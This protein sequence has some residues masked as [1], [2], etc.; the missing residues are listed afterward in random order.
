[1]REQQKRFS[2]QQANVQKQREPPAAP[3]VDG[4]WGRGRDAADN[5]LFGT[6]LPQVERQNR[7]NHDKNTRNR[8]DGDETQ[9]N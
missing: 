2:K 9:N 8:Q 3:T 4:N 5:F 6:G 1:M 7:A